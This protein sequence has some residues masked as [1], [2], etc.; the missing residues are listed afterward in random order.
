MRILSKLYFII[1]DISH[2]VFALLELSLFLRLIL[3]FLKANPKALAVNF[4][5]KVSDILVSPFEFMFLD[6]YWPEG[7]LIETTTISAMVGYCIALYIFLQLLH[8]ILRD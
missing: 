2:K 7:Y 3:K 6:L 1:Y 4:I 8:F 5:Y